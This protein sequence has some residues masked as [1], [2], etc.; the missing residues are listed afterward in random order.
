[1]M[2]LSHNALAIIACPG[3]NND[4]TLNGTVLGR[5]I[6]KMSYAYVSCDDA[7]LKF[8]ERQV[9]RWGELSCHKKPEPV[10]RQG[11]RCSQDG[12]NITIGW[13][14]IRGTFIPQISLCFS[15]HQGT[16]QFA[17]HKIHG[18]NIDAKV[19]DPPRPSFRDAALFPFRIRNSY[20]K[21]TQMFLLQSLLNTTEHLT[22]VNG[23]YLA[24]GHLAPDADF[25]LEAEQDATYYYANVV[26]QWQAINN[27]NWKSL[28]F[29]VRNLAKIRDV[30][31]EVWSGTHGT[32]MLPHR[33]GTPT[34][35]FL[36]L[37]YNLFL[38]PVPG[39]MW[40]VV[41]DPV[42]HTAT[43]IIMVND[44]R[45]YG[46]LDSRSL[47]DAPCHSLCSEL[48]WVRW[49]TSDLTR[50]GTFCCTIEDFR[51]IIP[52]LPSFGNVELLN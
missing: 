30:T 41:H 45:G 38:A 29:A 27:G 16:T 4:I 49:N 47:Y 19:V 50:G 22:G 43:A 48:S 44:V 9:V 12:V 21:S 5:S 35:I 13:D 51:S 23:H 32:L 31:L 25:V 28:E 20:L 37:I 36:G 40:K 1:M 26:P 42:S 15:H 2:H 24:K 14:I 39:L 52:D 10:L 17:F 33:H 6:N 3:E 18:R 8:G 7:D 34:K 11:A 46:T